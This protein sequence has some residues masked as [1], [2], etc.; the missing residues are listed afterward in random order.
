[1]KSLPQGPSN[2]TPDQFPGKILLAEGHT[3]KTDLGTLKERTV[4]LTGVAFKQ[5]IPDAQRT[6]F[7]YLMNW[8]FSEDL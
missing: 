3:K 5:K 8:L 2:P 7:S 4:T 6:K 1:L